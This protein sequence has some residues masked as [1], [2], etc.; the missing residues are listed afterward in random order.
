[1]KL[2]ILVVFNFNDI[3]LVSVDFIFLFI[4]Y[5]DIFFLLGVDQ[6]E[7]IFF[8]FFDVLNEVYCEIFFV[9]E[10][11]EYIVIW[12]GVKY[13]KEEVICISGIKIIYWML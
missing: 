5:R 12:E 9:C 2:C 13:L 8:L 6:E 7:S 11:N 10:I 4:Q 1:M 3:Y